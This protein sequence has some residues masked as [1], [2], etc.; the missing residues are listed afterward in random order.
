ME[1]NSRD[2]LFLA[3]MRPAMFAGMPLLA[4]LCN[5]GGWLMVFFMF[6]NPFIPPIP[7]LLC[8]F[9]LR[10]ATRTDHNVFRKLLVWFRTKAANTNTGLYG[11]A[12]LSPLQ[13]SRRPRK[14]VIP[15]V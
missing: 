1:V 6:K 3:C 14:E 7:F 13:L 10:M 9:G 2:Q 15:Y 5:V 4:F 12:S 11:G 8:H